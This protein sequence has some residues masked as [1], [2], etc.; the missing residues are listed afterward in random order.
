MSDRYT[1]YGTSFSLYTGKIR[2][3]L[4]KK[5]IPF[6]EV[7]STARVYKKF[8]IPRTGVRYIP[9]LQTPQNEV[10]QDTTHIIDTLEERFPDYSAYPD[11]PKQK[12]VSLLLEVYADEWVVIPAMHYRWAYQ[13]VNQPFIYQQF[14]KIVSPYLPKFI[15]ARLGKKL[16]SRFKGSLPLL[17][18]TAKSQAAIEVSFLGLLADLESHF[19][20]HKY[21]MGNRPCIADY[22]FI[23][24]FYAHLFHDPYPGALIRREAPAVAKW[25]E[26]MIDGK[27]EQGGFLENDVI[28][29]TLLAVL[30]RMASE[31]L[32]VLLDT[33]KKLSAWR[34]ANPDKQIPRSTGKHHFTVGGVSEQRVILPYS[35]W[36]F[37]RPVDFYHCLQG[38]EKAGVDELL[39]KAGFADALAKG[40]ENRLMRPD[41]TLKF[42]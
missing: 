12:L 2:S 42:A 35:L 25:I 21:L 28:P 29:D 17:G 24:P 1:L 32:P 16:G 40:L 37:K 15:R 13:E 18:I 3:Y 14:G 39:A 33:D 9:V 7:L 22:G 4:A 6:D 30:R 36:M 26:R 41:N 23:G 19:Q 11:Q 34:K 31:Q 27:P 10:Y 5:G 20:N 8:I 38:S